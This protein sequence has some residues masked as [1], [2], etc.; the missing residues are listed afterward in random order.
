MGG[1]GFQRLSSGQ[2]PID[3]NAT[4]NADLTSFIA[5]I[6]RFVWYGENGFI[7]F[8]WTHPVHR[9]CT[10]WFQ[11]C[12]RQPNILPTNNQIVFFVWLIVELQVCVGAYCHR[13][14]ETQCSGQIVFRRYCALL[15]KLNNKFT[16]SAWN[17]LTFYCLVDWSWTCDVI[18][19]NWAETFR[20]YSGYSVGMEFCVLR[21]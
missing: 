11:P 13:L 18:S 10:S 8:L 16:L 19:L 20:I 9:K 14:P 21:I 7:H 15:N 2:N 1:E 5:L 17:N 4:Y 6:S 3:E 12:Q